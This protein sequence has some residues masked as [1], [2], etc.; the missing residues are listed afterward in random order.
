M[1]GQRL[2]FGA[3]PAPAETIAINYKYPY[4]GIIHYLPTQIAIWW[5]N[6][7]LIAACQSGQASLYDLRSD[8]QE[9]FDIAARFPGVG[10]DLKGRLRA[11]LARQSGEP[12]LSCPNL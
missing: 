11:R 4:D 3:F 8:P 6:Y 12:R 2:K 9:R 7:K 5:D 10:E 1:D